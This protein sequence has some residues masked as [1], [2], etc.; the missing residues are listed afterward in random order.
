MDAGLN[1]LLGPKAVE[2][3]IS[4]EQDPAQTLLQHTMVETARERI[5]QS[6][7]ATRSHLRVKK[8]CTTS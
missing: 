8:I 4:P 7:N 5:S 1:G 2:Q 6:E 3:E